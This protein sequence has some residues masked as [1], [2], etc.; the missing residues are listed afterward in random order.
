MFE[1]M[2]RGD[3]SFISYSEILWRDI[4]GGVAGVKTYSK[5][6]LDPSLPFQRNGVI[7]LLVDTFYLLRRYICCTLHLG[8]V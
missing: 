5:A 1:P 4:D 2:L 3:D 8:H 6:S 7:A